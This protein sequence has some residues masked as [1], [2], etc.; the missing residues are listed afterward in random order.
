MFLDTSSIILVWISLV[1]LLF[2]ISKAFYWSINWDTSV[3]NFYELFTRK[4]C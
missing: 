1:F 3:L 2:F 4:R